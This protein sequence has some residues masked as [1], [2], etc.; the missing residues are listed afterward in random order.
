M[1]RIGHYRN[2][3]KKLVLHDFL[4]KILLRNLEQLK[5]DDTTSYIENCWWGPPTRTGV[6]PDNQLQT[7]GFLLFFIDRVD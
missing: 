4:Q 1:R 6:K 2:M 3:S 7:R 5:S